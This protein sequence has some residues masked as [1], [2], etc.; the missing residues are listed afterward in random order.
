MATGPNQVW[1]WDITK[2]A[3]PRRGVYHHLYV[4]IDS[5]LTQGRALSRR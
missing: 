3:G 5:P 2:L 1:S 4:M